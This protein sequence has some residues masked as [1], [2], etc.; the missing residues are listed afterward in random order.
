[1][2][3]WDDVRA[4]ALALPET[5]EEVGGDGNHAWQVK[6]K[7]FAWERPLR[8]KDLEAL[9]AAAPN[10]PILCARVPDVGA[11]E[12][13]LAEPDMGYFTTPHFN[14]YPAILVELDRI[15]VPE[16]EE[17]LVE[18]WLAKAPKRLANQYL[19]GTR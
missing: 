15:P 8:R 18:A 12:A 10:G 19:S 4:I 11:K 3:T 17:L 6:E 1:M 5:S 9:G 2:A 16:L 14:G 7:T 13:L